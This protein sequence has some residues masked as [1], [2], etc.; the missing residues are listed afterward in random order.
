MKE[1]RSKSGCVLCM[2]ALVADMQWK[3]HQDGLEAHATQ[4]EML[5]VRLHT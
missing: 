4:E 5:K 3:H 2:E 1:E